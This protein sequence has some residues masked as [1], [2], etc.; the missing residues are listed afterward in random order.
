MAEGPDADPEE[1]LP[2]AC[3]HEPGTKDVG[4]KA[5]AAESL[6]LARQPAWGVPPGGP[7]LPLPSLAAPSHTPVWNTG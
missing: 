3:G 6:H 2:I 4:Q 5:H 7:S 1:E